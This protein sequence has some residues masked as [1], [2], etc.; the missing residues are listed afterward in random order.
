M[1]VGSEESGSRGGETRKIAEQPDGKSGISKSRE[2]LAS[3]IGD[4]LDLGKSAR[5]ILE[6]VAAG[7]PDEHALLRRELKSSIRSRFLQRGSVKRY[8]AYSGRGEKIGK[9]GL[10]SFPE[11]ERAITRSQTAREIITNDGNTTFLVHSTS[12]ENAS[13]ILE[14]G[15]G[16]ADDPF[17]H[18][19][20]SLQYTTKMLAAHNEPGSVERNIHALAYRYEG[21]WSRAE[22]NGAKIV[23]EIPIPNPGTSIRKDP[24]KGT[25]FEHADGVNV[26][27]HEVSSDDEQPFIIPPERIRGYFNVETGEFIVNERFVPITPEEKSMDSRRM[28]TGR[29]KFDRNAIDTVLQQ[30]NYSPEALIEVFRHEFPKDYEAYGVGEHTITVL[31]QYDYYLS[32]KPLPLGMDRNLF[33]V[34]LALHDIGK[35][36]AIRRKGS[37]SFQHEYTVP[38]AEKALDKLNYSPQ[39]RDLAVAIISG[40]PIGECIKA[41]EV[42]EAAVKEITEKAERLHVPVQEFLNLMLVYY[43][44]DTSSYLVGQE[45]SLDLQDV[46]TVDRD[47]RILELTEEPQRVVDQMRERLALAA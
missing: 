12:E 34:M 26:V 47:N 24:F 8:F 33:K 7:E 5:K 41:G 44:S 31:S 4:S 40:D 20:P 32:D 17:D 27:P 37:S 3:R 45:V 11:D 43:K 15:L 2:R 30:K 29:V 13:N 39:E 19:K 1:S 35:R 18:D 46:F 14:H 42:K 28:E 9:Q 23:V 16:I 25:Q 10:L 21:G 38:M 22:D 36:K 6:D